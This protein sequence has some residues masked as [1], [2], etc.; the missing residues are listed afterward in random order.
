MRNEAD[1]MLSI[2]CRFPYEDGA[3]AISLIEESCSISPNAA[4]RVLYELACRPASCMAADGVI[5]HL[6]SKLHSELGHPFCETLFS[7]AERMSRGDSIS[8]LEAESALK[9]SQLYPGIY[10]ALDLIVRAAEERYEDAVEN[11]ANE[12]MSFW[13]ENEKGDGCSPNA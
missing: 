5:L 11:L 8:L 10:S 3:L 12:V 1:F 7:I 4:F 9:E 2:D 13:K 6:M